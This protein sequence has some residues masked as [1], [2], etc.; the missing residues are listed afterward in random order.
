MSLDEDSIIV[1]H[2]LSPEDTVYM[3]GKL[4]KG[5]ATDVGGKTSHTAIVAQGLEIPAVV[6]LRVISSQART[7]NIIVIDGNK[8]EIILNPNLEIIVRYKKEY[9][10]QFIKRKYL[11]KLNDLPSETTDHYK[12]LIYANIDHPDEVQSVLKNG[13]DGIDLYRT[14]CIY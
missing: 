7:G 8:G 13:A 14:E 5:F 3:R 6:G 11:E 10:I 12:V 1:A 2:A 4:F 9:D